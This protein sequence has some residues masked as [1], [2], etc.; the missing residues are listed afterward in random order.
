M[1]CLFSDVLTVTD[2]GIC[3]QQVELLPLITH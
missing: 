2:V 1:R 3:R